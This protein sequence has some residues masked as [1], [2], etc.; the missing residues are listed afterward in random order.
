LVL[1][2]ALVFCYTGWEWIRSGSEIRTESPETGVVTTSTITFES[3]SSTLRNIGLIVGRI[4]NEDSSL[5]AH[6]QGVDV[7]NARLQ[8]AILKDA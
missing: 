3:A 5:G 4:V 6:L 1:V 8:G 7:S 2:G